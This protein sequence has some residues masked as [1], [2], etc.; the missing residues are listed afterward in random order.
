VTWFDHLF[1]LAL[2]V[3]L[4]AYAAWD[5]R[6]LTR[7]VET[8]P[9]NARTNDYLWTIALQWVLAL[10]LIGWW[11]IAN[12]PFPEI[13]FVHPEGSRWWWTL[14]IVVTAIVFFS[15]QAYAV[16]SSPG[17]QAKVRKQL[18]SQPSVR[19]ILPANAR[20]MRVFGALAI[21][22][23]ICEEVLYRGY[24]F[25]YLRSFWPGAAA[26]IAAVVIFGVAHLY[27]GGR[28]II[29]TSIAGGAAMGLYLLTGSLIAPILV[30]AVLDLANGFMAYRALLSAEREGT[31]MERA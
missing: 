11:S 2:I 3:G 10:T 28:G 26:A 4:P 1:A 21:T 20:E 27:Q 30:H 13:G 25:W 6:Q 14:A 12:R 5:V 16:A 9:L 18:A 23:G 19:V 8:D 29:L 22:A 24:L 31:P 17:A 15:W 7:R